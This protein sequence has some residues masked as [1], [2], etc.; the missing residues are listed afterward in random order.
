MSLKEKITQCLRG[1]S[2]P[3]EIVFETKPLRPLKPGEVVP[4]ELQPFVHNG[5]ISVAAETAFYRNTRNSDGIA[6]N[7][8]GNGSNGIL[9]GDPSPHWQGR[10][11]KPNHKTTRGPGRHSGNG[12]GNVK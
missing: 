5:K 12:N 3:G 7:L 6:P 4:T 1:K 10:S 9:F 8:A 11:Q 2:N